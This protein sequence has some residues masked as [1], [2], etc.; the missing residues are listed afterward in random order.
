MFEFHKQMWTEPSNK[1]AEFMAAVEDGG[2]KLL[3]EA[4]YEYLNP[5]SSIDDTQ[6]RVEELVPTLTKF[7]NYHFTH[8][9]GKANLFITHAITYEV[10]VAARPYVS[11]W[12]ANML[13]SLVFEVPV[14]TKAYI[15]NVGRLDVYSPTQRSAK[16][17]RLRSGVLL[18]ARE[19]FEL[20]RPG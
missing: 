18:L 9:A 4:A 2:C 20:K 12:L 16:A 13:Y 15:H 6:S 10:K 5:D 11:H 3:R 8:K 14:S 7:A 19:L 17:Q 1:S